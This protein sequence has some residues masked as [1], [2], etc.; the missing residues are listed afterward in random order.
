[1]RTLA[2]GAGERDSASL[3]VVTEC[4]VGDYVFVAIVNAEGGYV[5]GQE[6]PCHFTGY[7][8]QELQ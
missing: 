2:D 6:S 4:N 7:L 3:T 5:D 1:M 8:L